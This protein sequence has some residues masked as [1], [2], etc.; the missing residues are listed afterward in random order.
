MRERIPALQARIAKLEE[1]LGCGFSQADLAR[2]TD[3]P[4]PHVS[5]YF[6]G[7]LDSEMLE[8]AI[9]EMISE[10][11]ESSDAEEDLEHVS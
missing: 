11:R 9:E 1:Y 4:T 6:S 3:V 8:A 5:L 10:K 7:K 2:R